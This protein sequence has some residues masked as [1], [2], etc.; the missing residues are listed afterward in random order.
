[1]D[2]YQLNKGHDGI[3]KQL[4]DVRNDRIGP[5][6]SGRLGSNPAISGFGLPAKWPLLTQSR[7]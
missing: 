4:R 7:H 1:M 6:T 3:F 2:G 5:L